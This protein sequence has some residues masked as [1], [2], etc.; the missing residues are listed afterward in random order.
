MLDH[1]GQTR[2]SPQADGSCEPSSEMGY[3]PDEIVVE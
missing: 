1:N 3:A 2:G